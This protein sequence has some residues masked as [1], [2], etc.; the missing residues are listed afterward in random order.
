MILRSEGLGELKDAQLDARL[1]TNESRPSSQV[2]I[3][4]HS[5]SNEYSFGNPSH[6]H[7]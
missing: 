6:T 7:S 5:P 4:P 2:L 1:A 3:V